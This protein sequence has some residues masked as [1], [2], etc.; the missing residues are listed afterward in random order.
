MNNLGSNLLIHPRTRAQ[1][2]AF[3][4][5]PNHGLLLTGESG[6]GKKTLSMWLATE[7]LGI[8]S[9]SELTNYPYIKVIDNQENTIGIDEVR[10]LKHFL[11][12]KTPDSHKGVRR[13]IVLNDADKLTHEAQ[14]AFLK[15]LEEPPKDTVIILTSSYKGALRPTIISRVTNIEVMPV[16]LTQVKKHFKD[17]S[18]KAYLEKYFLISRGQ[19]GILASLFESEST[20]VLNKINEAKAILNMP[21]GEKLAAVD[22]LAKDKE[23]LFSVID[24]LKRIARGALMNSAQKDDR[25]ASMRWQGSLIAIA[26]AQESLRKNANPKLILDELF[27][28]L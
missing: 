10:D 22:A 12:L 17:H 28:N 2:D 1:L 7:L 25:T 27:L 26:A 6:S 15:A 16:S 14:N 9:V 21:I 4:K 13:V 5:N 23:V 18:D 8:K 11:A 3:I 19:V 20:S 24:A